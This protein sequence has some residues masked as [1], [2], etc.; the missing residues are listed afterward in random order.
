[1]IF[2]AVQYRIECIIIMQKDTLISA[3][4]EACSRHNIV[5]VPSTTMLFIKTLK[6]F[7]CDHKSKNISNVFVDNVVEITKLVQPR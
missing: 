6:D 3:F 4:E 1:M 2:V 7:D 5:L